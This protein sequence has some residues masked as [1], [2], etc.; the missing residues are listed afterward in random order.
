MSLDKMEQ[1]PTQNGQTFVAAMPDLSPFHEG[2]LVQKAF[3]KR[4][5]SLNGL[6]KA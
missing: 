6:N 1:R 2:F 5:R 4:M 3:G